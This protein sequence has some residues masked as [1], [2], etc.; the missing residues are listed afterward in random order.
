MQRIFPRAANAR[1]RVALAA[2]LV[3]AACARPAG[4]PP[5]PAPETATRSDTAAEARAEAA[6]A[7]AARAEAAQ[8]ESARRDS[9]ARNAERR[10]TEARRRVAIAADTLRVCAGGDVTLGTNLD[11][12]WAKRATRILQRPVRPFVNP[13]T[14]LA[15][16][17]PL[18]R[19]ADVVL[20]NIEG[21]IGEGPA[22]RKC[23]PGSTNCYA[24]RQQPRVAGA[25]RRVGGGAEVVGNV[26][27][28]HARDA[29]ESGL[30]A[31]T[32]HLAR[33]GVHVTGADTLP[34]VVTTPAGDTVA[35]LGFSTSGGPDPR[36]R[37]AVRRHVARAAAR[38]A[39]VVVTMHMG[40]EGAGAQR[41]ADTTEL[42]LG[43]D[44][45]NVV[46]FARDAAAS[47]ADLVVG[48]GPHVMRAGEWVGATLALYSLG[49]LATYGPFTLRDPLDRGALACATLDGEGRV[50]AAELRSTR[51]RPPG[52]VSA[53]PTARAAALVDSLSR[54]DFP[55]TGV[56]VAAGG[57]IEVPALVAEY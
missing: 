18:A 45:G 31:T 11:T 47:G 33:A 49:N 21:A 29:G 34:T 10:E 42:F 20:L 35:F 16:L 2:V 9:I 27:N 54:L 7:E 28:N 25:L 36:D 19:G 8:A 52:F 22:P 5:A 50:V 3:A 30:A 46:A 6:R 4:P 39:R 55:R 1:P 23:A 57:R 51:Q 24:F 38:H 48:H 32:A 12:T 40:A 44:R 56:R 26:A 41:T 15:P 37:A 14:L 13:D 17:R 43:I 53:D